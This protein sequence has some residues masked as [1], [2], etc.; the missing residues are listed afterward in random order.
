M[1]TLSTER[2]ALVATILGTIVGWGYF[3]AVM[4]RAYAAYTVV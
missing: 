3:V 4:A 2:T 1:Q